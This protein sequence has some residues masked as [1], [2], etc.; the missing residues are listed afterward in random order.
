MTENQRLRHFIKKLGLKQIDVA[1]EIGEDTS[2]LS[3]MLTGKL[4]LQLDMLQKM[5]FKYYLNLNWILCGSGKMRYTDDE[6]TRI[7]EEK[8]ASSEYVG[9]KDK[10]LEALEE[11]RKLQGK[12]AWYIENCTCDKK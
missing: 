10:Y 6:K 9:Y 2:S 5:H 8:D 4:Q 11:I 1:G 12:L 7:T 3:K